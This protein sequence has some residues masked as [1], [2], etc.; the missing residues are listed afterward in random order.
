MSRYLRILF[1]IIVVAFT[2]LISSCETILPFRNNNLE[3]ISITS[4]A[5]SDSI[6]YAK[7]TRTVGVDHT[8]FSSLEKQFNDTTSYLALPDAKVELIINHS[9][10]IILQYDKDKHRYKCNYIVHQGDHLALNVECEGFGGSSAEIIVPTQKEIEIVDCTK[11]FSKKPVIIGD[12]FM[13]DIFGGDTLIVI[14]LRIKDPEN[15]KNFYRLRA[16]AG[17]GID[18]NEP[19]V[20]GFFYVND[21]FISDDIIFYNKDI[22]EP[23]NGWPSNFFNV[24]DDSL[25]NGKD[26]T[27][28]IKIRKRGIDNMQHYV[29]I[30]FE[31]I[32][33]DL[34]KYFL[35]ERKCQISNQSIYAEAVYVPSNINN[36][37]GVFGG[38]SGERKIIVL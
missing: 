31:S 16:R 37:F 13:T 18:F 21:I 20:S 5:S 10:S 11:E 9:D 14:T 35:A 8:I 17:S 36:G 7:V 6:L 19:N 30:D 12:D 22:T 32:T 1:S 33:E 4:I 2:L 23:Y 38:M 26:Y 3:L 28:T 29:C 15:E 24:F 34:Y 25:I 27:F